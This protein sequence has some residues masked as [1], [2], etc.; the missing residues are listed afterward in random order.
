MAEA[1]NVTLYAKGAK[2]WKFVIDGEG[3]LDHF[4]E[5]SAP[6]GEATIAD[7]KW[8]I[9]TLQSVETWLEHCPHDLARYGAVNVT[10]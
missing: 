7:Y 1:E 6:F 10:C 2:M 3:T 9:E 8:L 4:D 5:I